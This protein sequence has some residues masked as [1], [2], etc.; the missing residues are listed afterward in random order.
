MA[1]KTVA[2]TYK[3]IDSDGCELAEY[4]DKKEAKEALRA[5]KAEDRA[6]RYASI[7]EIAR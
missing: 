1:T 7:K 4:G 3:L 5:L 6:Y 2:K